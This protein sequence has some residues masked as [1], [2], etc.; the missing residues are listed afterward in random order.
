[1]V[2]QH[3]T[4]SSL[5]VKCN[6]SF[7][8]F[9]L[10]NWVLLDW[11]SACIIVLVQNSLLW[12]SQILISAKMTVIPLYWVFG[13]SLTFDVF[14]IYSGTVLGHSNGWL[15]Y[16]LPHLAFW[17]IWISVLKIGALIFYQSYNIDY[18]SLY[19]L[20]LLSL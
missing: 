16:L 13:V 10:L 1:M 12:S 14:S 6:F 17:N 8:I 20:Y 18:S 4:Q 5:S 15:L 2:L 3:A 7:L 11:S 19:F 9:N